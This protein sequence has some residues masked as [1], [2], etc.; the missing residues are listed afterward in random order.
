MTTM[1]DGQARTR[2]MRIGDE[3]FARLQRL[4]RLSG[5]AQY[6]MLNMAI[7]ELYA[8]T[9]RSPRHGDTLRGLEAQD[10]AEARDPVWGPPAESR[11]NQD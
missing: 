1:A 5:R 8:R 4:V 3:Q 10:A 9:L 11:E 2:G 6:Q 7:D